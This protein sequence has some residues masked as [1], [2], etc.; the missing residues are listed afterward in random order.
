MEKFIKGFHRNRK[1]YY[2]LIVFIVTL[3]LGIFI[4]VFGIMSNS[5]SEAEQVINS[6][7]YYSLKGNP[8]SLERDLFDKLTSEIESDNPQRLVI[9]ELVAKSF[10]ADY[11]TWSNKAGVYD[12]GGSEFIMP[13]E[14]TNFYFSSR[15]YYYNKMY[16]YINTNIALTDLVEVETVSDS[17]ASYSV[18]YD[19]YGTSYLSFYIEL[20][21]TY[22]ESEIIDTTLFPNSAAITLIE[23]E[24]GRIEVVRFY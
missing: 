23:R 17:I 20:S 9:A 11:Y 24:D 7:D 13:E 15:L 16:D 14:G 10:V 12:I 21:W 18:D 5:S 4:F 19:Y 3:F 6:N 2:G 8:T 1:L 22:K